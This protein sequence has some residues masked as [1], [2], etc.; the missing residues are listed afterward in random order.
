MG[1]G[2]WTLV[3][4]A[5]QN[6]KYN[7]TPKYKTQNPIKLQNTNFKFKNPPPIAQCL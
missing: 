2:F 7:K 5:I 6:I 4:I 3:P 1:G